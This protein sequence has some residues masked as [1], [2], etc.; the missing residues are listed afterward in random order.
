[1]IRWALIAGAVLMSALASS[2]L[3]RETR[4]VMRSDEPVAHTLG[5]YAADGPGV[6]IVFQPEDCLGDGGIVRRWNALATAPALHVSGL[7]V[8]G[9]GVSPA[10]AKVFAEF[11]L[12]MPVASISRLDAEILAGKLGYV[13][14]P[15]AV[16]LDSSGRV[17]AS[18]PAGQNVPPEVVSRLVS[19]T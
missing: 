11:G 15:F 16:V 13:S 5:R 12:R 8:G 7:V 2:A 19:G 10:Q 17:A 4:Y 3:L 9:A 14:T 6:V 1:V 18:F